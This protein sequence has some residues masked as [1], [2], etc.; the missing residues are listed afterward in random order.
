M[1]GFNWEMDRGKP[2]SESDSDEFEKI[3]FEYCEKTFEYLK[4]IVSGHYPILQK[5]SQREKDIE[6]LKRLNVQELNAELIELT[7]TLS[8]EE[9]KEA[10]QKIAQREKVIE[11]LKELDAQELKDICAKLSEDFEPAA[12]ERER[13]IEAAIDA[14]TFPNMEISEILQYKYRD[15]DAEYEFKRDFENFL[16]NVA[17]EHRYIRK[18]L[19]PSDHVYGYVGRYL[20]NPSWYSSILTDFLLVD[21]FDAELLLLEKDFHFGIFPPRLADQ[22]SGS[23]LFHPFSMPMT[24]YSWRLPP[25]E[26][27]KRDK[28]RIKYLSIGLVSLYLWIGKWNGEKIL[29]LF[30]ND[31]PSWIV[32]IIAGL[33]FS[34]LSPIL[35]ILCEVLNKNKKVIKKIR[36]AT[37]HFAIIRFEIADQLHHAETLYHAETLIERLKK[38][39]DL[40][41]CIPSLIYALLELRGEQSTTVKSKE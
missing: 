3:S 21:I 1:K 40:N 18:H 27:K 24:I 25:K 7:V 10:L 6:R 5:M 39:E 28:W 34:S 37:L 17:F 13:L 8:V 22:M 31:Y 11:G 19:F 14:S 29:D 2:T 12:F 38:L 15:W 41:L 9:R 4:R 33:A 20:E 32:G 35:S 16:W 36:E 30:L 26:R 23:E